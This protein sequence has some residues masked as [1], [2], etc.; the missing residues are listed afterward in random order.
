MELLASLH[1]IAKLFIIY[2]VRFMDE[3]KSVNKRKKLKDIM[4]QKSSK[5][6]KISTI[7]N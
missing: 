3:E 5:E 1:D 6:K 7:L 2:N 4:G